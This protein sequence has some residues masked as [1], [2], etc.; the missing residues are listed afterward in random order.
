MKKKFGL[1]VAGIMTA[2]AL[3]SFAAC[4]KDGGD[5]GE[6]VP[7]DAEI[8]ENVSIRFWGWGDA[9]EQENYQQLVNQ[10]MQEN[11]NITVVYT[12]MS[13][14]NYMNEL[15]NSATNLP[16]LFYMPDYDFLEYAANG[17]LKDVSSYVTEEE[18]AAIWPNAVDEYYF[19]PNNNKLGKSDGAKLYGLPKDLGPFT[20]VYNKTLLDAQIAKYN[21]NSEEVYALLSPKTPM[22]W[23]QFRELLKSLVRRTSTAQYPTDSADTIYGISHYE[24]EA[25][26]Y[27]NDANFFNDDASEQRITDK[28]FTDALQFIADLS[29]VDHTMVEAENQA[30]TNGFQRFINQ[31]CIFSFM[32]PWD[33]AQFWNIDGLNFRSNIIPMPYNG[34]NP[35]ARS[36]AWVGSMGYCVSAKANS[37]KTNAAMRLAKY[38]CYNEDAQRKFYE[39]GQQVPN[40]MEMAKD[41]YVNDTRDL[42]AGKDPADRSVWLDTID[43]FS[44]TDKIGGKVRPRYYTYSSDWYDMFTEYIDT[45]GL[46]KG[47][48]TAAQIC[49]AYAKTFQAALNE[50]RANLG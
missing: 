22:T 15:R 25:A 30:S 4:A 35:N 29:L 2:S 24:I 39:L 19:N 7:P 36:T 48:K 9:A 49:E 40:L 27:S 16:E 23:Q 31:G 44:E 8:T 50:M 33:C 42:I 3:V 21:L 26:I 14:A 45:Q 11:K 6:Y 18:L 20:L 38:L 46:W 41:E 13:S 28:N 37:L 17:M 1:L 32:G 5:E 34:E 12:G 10:F 47:T 43:G